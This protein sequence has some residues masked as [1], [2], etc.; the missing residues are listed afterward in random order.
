MWFKNNRVDQSCLETWERGTDRASLTQRYLSD[1]YSSIRSKNE[2]FVANGSPDG[3]PLPLDAIVRASG[4]CT[5]RRPIR[6]SR[7]VSFPKTSQKVSTPSERSSYVSRRKATRPGRYVFIRLRRKPGPWPGRNAIVLLR[8]DVAPRREAD[9]SPKL[10]ER[11]RATVS[12]GL[13][14]DSI[15]LS[16]ITTSCAAIGSVYLY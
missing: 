13:A 15:T 11:R 10:E 8:R 16:V 4:F 5:R 1:T 12:P 6:K 2:L 14:G 7:C 9:A 3:L